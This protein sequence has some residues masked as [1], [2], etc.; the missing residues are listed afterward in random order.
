VLSRIYNNDIGPAVGGP[1]AWKCHEPK[2]RDISR[3][4]IKNGPRRVE[5][6]MR[7]TANRLREGFVE[8]G[9]DRWP[10]AARSATSSM[11]FMFLLFS[12]AGIIKYGADA[13]SSRLAGGRF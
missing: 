2:S 11:I 1:V 10:S 13:S 7:K 6:A 5:G 8:D 12:L 4:Q 3:L 9:P